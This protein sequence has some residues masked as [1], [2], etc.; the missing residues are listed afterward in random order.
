M[1]V[2]PSPW[3]TFA[4][5]R[6]VAGRVIFD[7]LPAREE[8]RFAVQRGEVLHEATSSFTMRPDQR[9]RIEFELEPLERD[10]EGDALPLAIRLACT[11]L[12]DDERPAGF[13][14]RE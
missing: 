2:D 5:R 13:H 7:R 4:G 1:D 3:T 9:A 6:L 14:W 12:L 11:P 8:L 10:A